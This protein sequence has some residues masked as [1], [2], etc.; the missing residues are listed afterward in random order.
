V[1][2]YRVEQSTDSGG[3]VALSLAGP[4]VTATVRALAPGHSY[5]YR[6]RAVDRA[7]LWSGWAYG[8]VLRPALYQE[9]TTALGWAGYWIRYA[10]AGA[11]GGAVRGSSQAG[12][13]ARFTASARSVGWVAVRAPNRGRAS[14]YV[15]GVLVGTV[16]LYATTVQPARLVFVRSWTSVG[17]HSVTVR[18]SGTTGRPRVEVDAFALLR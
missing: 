12:A 5:Q 7:G 18:V 15:D 17:T 8:P 3:W 13:W 10:V 16:D 4:L 2:G 14:V 6:V 11:S 9:T 1:A